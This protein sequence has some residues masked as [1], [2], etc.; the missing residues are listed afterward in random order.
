VHEV[1]ARQE[2][3]QV[4]ADPSLRTCRGESPSTDVVKSRCRCG[5]VPALP[6]RERSKAPCR[7]APA[8]F[9][10][11]RSHGTRPVKTNEIPSDRDCTHAPAAERIYIEQA[12]CLL[13]IAGVALY[14]VW[15]TLLGAK[16]GPLSEVQLKQGGTGLSGNGG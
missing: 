4:L 16:A 7:A 14:T 12:V 10:W 11:S 13:L 8:E 1:V 9:G 2:R 3:R 15:R 5:T 6:G